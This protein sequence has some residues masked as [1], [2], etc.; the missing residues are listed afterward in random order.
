LD[1]VFQGFRAHHFPAG[2]HCG[3]KILKV[4]G[5]RFWHF[6]LGFENSKQIFYERQVRRV[7]GSLVFDL[8]LKMVS[9]IL[10]F[11]AL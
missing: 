3:L 8:E 11:C 4:L 10:S 7:W 2:F 9:Q 1:K 6:Y 5:V